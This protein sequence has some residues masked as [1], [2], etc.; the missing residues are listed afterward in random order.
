[1]KYKYDKTNNVYYYRCNVQKRV[2]ARSATPEGLEK[3][4]EEFGMKA[5]PNLD[6][7]DITV[8][9]AFELFLKEKQ[10][11]EVRQKT[12]NDYKNFIKIYDAENNL[13]I[14][15][16][17]IKDKKLVNINREYMKAVLKLLLHR[18]SN[19]SEI[20]INHWYGILKNA[21]NVAYI[22]F[23]F[24][25][26]P[27]TD[28][29]L[30]F[31]YEKKRGWSPTREGAIQLLEAV[32]KYCDPCHALFTKF[33]AHGLRASE[34]N[35]L[36][37]EDFDFMRRRFEVSRSIDSVRNLNKTKSKSSVRFVN[38]D[39]KFIKQVIEYTKGMKQTDWL[40]LGKNNLPKCQKTL[41]DYGLKKAIKKLK[42]TN[43]DFIWKGGLHSLRHY[44]ASIVL[45]V[46]MSNGKSPIWIAKQLGHSSFTTTLNLYGHIIDEDDENIAEELN[47]M[48]QKVL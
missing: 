10:P 21:L 7:H 36:K 24:Q 25:N 28:K 5:I 48:K 11:P 38:M 20:S 37:V 41:R 47:P 23:K 22:H 17:L 46:G 26:N 8:A 32:D 2:I 44:Y 30:K 39:D 15:N 6:R 14:D 12:Y 42:E 18:Y 29:S 33:C 27:M 16:K 9:D 31:D 43:P 40:F 13:R 1:M 19:K 3:K 45:Q 35:A 4:L 34:A